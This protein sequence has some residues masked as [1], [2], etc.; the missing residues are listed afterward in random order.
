MPDRLPRL[1]AL[2]HPTVSFAAI[3]L[4]AA[5]AS[6]GLHSR[7]RGGAALRPR[8]ARLAPWAAGVTIANTLLGIASVAAWRPD[9]RLAGGPHFW[10]GIAIAS[11]LAAG[12]A[13]SRA[14][15]RDERARLVHPLLGLVALLLAL[16]QVFFGLSL[17][18]P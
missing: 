16:V 13:A 4:L 9:L 18:A 14:V 1:L 12:A 5:A 6:L 15:H 7:E 2:V 10:L 8:H 3:A 17:V 11:L